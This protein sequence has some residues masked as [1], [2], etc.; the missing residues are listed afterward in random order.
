MNPLYS[1]EN[2]S[3]NT[4]FRVIQEIKVVQRFDELHKS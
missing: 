3:K 4:I 2:L 1:F